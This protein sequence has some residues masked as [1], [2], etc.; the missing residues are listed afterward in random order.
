M[1][2]VLEFFP[3]GAGVFGRDARDE[4]ALLVRHQGRRDFHDLDG[5]L[6]RAEDHFGKTFAQRPVGVH[7]GEAEIRHG[8]G[9]KRV[10]HLLAA[11]AAGAKFFEELNGF[12]RRHLP[13]LP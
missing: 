3:Q 9:L 13:T 10:Q 12:S 11:H 2:G 4:D 5:R 8:R 1:D 6:A 7:L